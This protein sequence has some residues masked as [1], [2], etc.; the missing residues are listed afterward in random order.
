MK[1]IR[2]RALRLLAI[3]ILLA[4]VLLVTKSA[5]AQSL[6][7]NAEN[8]SRPPA[9]PRNEPFVIVLGVVPI[10][11][12]AAAAGP[13]S[14]Q[15]FYPA[16][17][18]ATTQIVGGG[19]VVNP[20]FRF[21]A[22]AIFNEVFTGL[23]AQAKTWQFGGLAPVAVG[24]LNHFIVGGGPIFGYRSG[25]RHQSDAGAVALTG[26]SIPMRKGLAVNVVAPV[27]ALFT[28]RSTVSVGIAA[29]VA[30]VF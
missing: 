16:D 27:T 3:S 23:P 21:G 14:S 1:C 22:V 7:T 9:G 5:A 4:A 11:T 6:D 19:Y 13:Q 29:G 8:D 18:F 24:T 28:H 2:R 30:K 12:Y 25:G 17:R 26:A 20:R 10:A 15:M